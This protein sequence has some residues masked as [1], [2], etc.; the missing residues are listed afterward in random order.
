MSPVSGPGH[1][2]L[3]LVARSLDP[4]GTGRTFGRRDLLTR[5]RKHRWRQTRDPRH[6]A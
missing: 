6:R 3:C 1:G 5:C 4:T 2:I